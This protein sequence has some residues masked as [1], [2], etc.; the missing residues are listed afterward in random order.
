MS[1]MKALVAVIALLM[2]ALSSAQALHPTPKK[3]QCGTILKVD[4]ILYEETEEETI[5]SV[6]V[7]DDGKATAFHS[8]TAPAFG[9][10]QP[11]PTKWNYSAE[12]DK[13]SLSDLRKIVRRPD[14][15]HL[16]GASMPLKLIRLLMS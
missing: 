15:A 6:T 13:D 1:L 9:A 10:A 4:W 12:I 7:C 14:I 5:D 8:F 16:P 3:P 2:S 11:E